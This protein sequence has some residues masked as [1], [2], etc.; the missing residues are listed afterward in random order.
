MGKRIL[1]RD[2][3]ARNIN[4]VSVMI[5]LQLNIKIALILSVAS[6]I[7]CE[8]TP[9][10]VAPV[11]EKRL[12]L[13]DT[14]MNLYTQEL[15]QRLPNDPKPEAL[16]LTP[17]VTALTQDADL[18]NDRSD[19]LNSNGAKGFV[20]IKMDALG[21]TLADQTANYTDN[22]WSCVKD[23]ITGLIW[24]VKTSSGLQKGTNT[25]TWYNPDSTTNGNN[26][27]TQVSDANCQGTL[28]NCNTHEYINTINQL[29]DGK[30]LCNL[31]NWRL[32]LREELRSLVDYSVS[33]TST[34]SSNNSMIDV[35]YFPNGLDTDNWSS[36]TE[37]DFDNT[38]SNAWVVHFDTGHA[39]THG[40]DKVLVVVRLVHD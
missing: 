33:P 18:G 6:L 20:F 37:V 25:Y 31:T 19:G 39:T 27:G 22:P 8:Q 10:T 23:E 14:G 34:T 4:S 26:A 5:N 38:G 35:N 15:P 9:D 12:V 24:E 21:N 11:E 32:P 3:S 40:K 2:V 16:T 17:D 28:T 30:G 7:A 1:W 13:N 36:Q 29:N